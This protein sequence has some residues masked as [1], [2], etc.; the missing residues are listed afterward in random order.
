MRT[1]GLLE[2][3]KHQA[4]NSLLGLVKL[5]RMRRLSSLASR[6]RYGRSS[7]PGAILTVSLRMMGFRGGTGRAR[8]RRP[9]K[10][11]CVLTPRHSSGAAWCGSF[12]R[13]PTCSPTEAAKRGREAWRYSMASTCWRRSRARTTSAPGSCSVRCG[14]SASA[15][16]PRVLGRR[17][18][19]GPGD[20][21]VAA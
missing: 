16:Q 20:P 3:V 1:L 21:G 17:Q 12:I 14:A 10:W 4:I 7:R 19:W 18:G 13:A 2:P 8:W 5:P 11:W 6:R 15:G 9:W